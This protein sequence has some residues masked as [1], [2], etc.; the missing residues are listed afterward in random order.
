MKSQTIEYW[1]KGIQALGRASENALRSLLLVLD[2]GVAG[3]RG[4][5][6][7]CQGIQQEPG[8]HEKLGPQ[9]SSLQRIVP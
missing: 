9:M 7:V 5:G 2:S 1:L 6:G 4:V 8:H 3:S